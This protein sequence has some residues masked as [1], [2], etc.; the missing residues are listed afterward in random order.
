M[1]EGE[2][3]ERNQCK[4]KRGREGGKPRNRGKG[5][6]RHDEG[7]E[8][9]RRRLNCVVEELVATLTLACFLKDIG[10]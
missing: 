10:S 1:R 7:M 3:E 9:V 6:R 2:L 5:E 4:R 8:K